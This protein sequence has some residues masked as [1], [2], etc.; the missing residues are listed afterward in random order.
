MTL[1]VTH[2]KILYHTYVN[3]QQWQN[4]GR[5]LCIHQNKLKFYGSYLYEVLFTCHKVP[6]SSL[7]EKLNSPSPDFPQ[8]F[9][10]AGNQTL[11]WD[12]LLF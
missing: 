1:P 12:P 7:H 5:F 9:L 8:L 11:I 3:V 6:A 4:H 10:I 2:L